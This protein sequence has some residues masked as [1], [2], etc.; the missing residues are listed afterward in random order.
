MCVLDLQSTGHKFNFRQ[1]HFQVQLW[2]SCSHRVPLSTHSIKCYW[3]NSRSCCPCITDN[4]GISIYRL[5]ATETEIGTLPTVQLEYLPL[6]FKLCILLRSRPPCHHPTNPQKLLLFLVP[7]GS[8]GTNICHNELHLHFQRVQAIS[9]YHFDH[10]IQESLRLL[11]GSNSNNSW[12]CA[13]SF[14]ISR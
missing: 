10:R 12:S 11:M 5:T 2:E 13:F 4:S 6:L 8:N 9:I 7:S 3:S 1:P 14:F